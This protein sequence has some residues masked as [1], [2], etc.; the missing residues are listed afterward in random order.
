[1]LTIRIETLGSGRVLVASFVALAIALT[2]GCR[3]P[4]GECGGAFPRHN[5]G[6]SAAPARRAE[7]AG[8]LLRA[9]VARQAAGGPGGGPVAGAPASA[10]GVRAAV[11]GA[12]AVAAARAAGRARVGAA[13]S[14][15][16]YGAAG[17]LPAVAGRLFV[18]AAV[19]AEAVLRAAGPGDALPAR[20]LGER[21]RASRG[22]ETV[23]EPRAAGLRHVLHHAEP[24]RRPGRRRVAPDADDLEQHPRHWT[25]WNRCRTWTGRGS[26]WR[27]RPAADCRRRCSPRSMPRV[28]AATIVGLT[29]DFRQ[30]MFPDATH[31]ACNH[32]PERH[33]ADRPSGNQH[34]GT[35]RRRPI[36]DDERL[37]QELRGRTTSRRS[38]SCTPPTAAA[39]ACSAS[40]STPS[41]TTTGRNA[42]TRTGG[43]SAGCA[44]RRPKARPPSPKRRRF[45]WRR[46]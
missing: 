31:C 41:T 43:W 29:C 44:A 23:L 28:K 25:T 38:R 12:V 24:L 7:A 18:R 20:P 30:I 33:A 37:D 42:S 36:P 45:P 4:A 40:T 6:R 27:G 14:S 8:G 32:F 15:V 13:G 2:A 16:V 5:A 1:M 10:A 46:S 3:T 39:S 34:A 9:D 35:A 22:P 19:P 17:V 26:A 11:C 21:E